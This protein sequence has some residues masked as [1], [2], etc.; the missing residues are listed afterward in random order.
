[1][2]IEGYITEIP[3]KA[4]KALSTVAKVT[5][6]GLMISHAATAF[7]QDSNAFNQ[8]A[9]I[10]SPMQER[11][12][13]FNTHNDLSSSQ[14]TLETEH[15]SFS[16]FNKSTILEVME[17]RQEYLSK[18]ELVKTNLFLQDQVSNMEGVYPIDQ[19]SEMDMIN[20][21]GRFLHNAGVGGLDKD[22]YLF[23][24]DDR[25]SG[26]ESYSIV[27]LESITEFNDE[28]NMNH[29]QQMAQNISINDFYKNETEVTSLDDSYNKSIEKL[30]ASDDVN[31]NVKYEIAQHIEKLGLFQISQMIDTINLDTG[32]TIT[33]PN[34][35]DAENTLEN[36]N[37]N[38]TKNKV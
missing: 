5:L 28:F 2:K 9:E 38:K 8:F 17:D 12:F 6:A 10:G 25:E 32:I 26:I 27:V 23:T 11:G 4:I 33:I 22:L 35:N 20:N 19:L 24:A 21:A 13:T 29:K 34:S 15:Q 31:D 36:K 1:M 18:K 3:K 14:M 7:S 30:K 37:K 16:K